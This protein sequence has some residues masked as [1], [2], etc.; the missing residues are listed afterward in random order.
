MSCVITCEYAK[1]EQAGIDLDRL[2][3]GSRSWFNLAFDLIRDNQ[4]MMELGHE[5]HLMLQWGIW[6][7]RNTWV[8][9]KEWRE[10]VEAV[11]ECDSFMLN[12]T[13]VLVVEKCLIKETTTPQQTSWRALKKVFIW[14]TLMKLIRMET[15]G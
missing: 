12:F 14:L 8:F 15:G 6:K 2:A 5:R 4:W 7:S 1:A 9:D 10:A 3:R 13:Q 11:A